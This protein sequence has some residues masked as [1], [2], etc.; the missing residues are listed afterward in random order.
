MFASQY[1]QL[2][3]SF[4]MASCDFQAD[5]EQENGNLGLGWKNILKNKV[6][7]VL[8]LKV[9]FLQGLEL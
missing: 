6:F 7:Q 4:T 1:S 5:K 3:Q 2:P 8:I 9:S